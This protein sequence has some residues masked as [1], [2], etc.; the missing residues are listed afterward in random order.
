MNIKLLCLNALNKTKLSG[1]YHGRPKAEAGKGCP[2]PSD[3]FLTRP[4]LV[5]NSYQVF[6]YFT[7]ENK[8]F[9]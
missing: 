7:P 1:I 2:P 8:N 4:G 6:M 5:S 3:L 9:F